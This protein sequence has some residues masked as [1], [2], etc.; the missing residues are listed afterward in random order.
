MQVLICFSNIALKIPEK[1]EDIVQ[2][3]NLSSLVL[4][5]TR[6][7]QLLNH[8]IELDSN[9]LHWTKE[10]VYQYLTKTDDCADVALKCKDEVWCV[11]KESLSYS[12]TEVSDFL[13]KHF[14]SYC[15]AHTISHYFLKHYMHDYYR[16][17]P[18]Q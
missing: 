10:D 2:A 4:L 11:V 16:L 18:N 7:Q 17:V 6:E 12:K 9:P 8:Q 5:R 1:N 15:L 3:D 14:L 13:Q